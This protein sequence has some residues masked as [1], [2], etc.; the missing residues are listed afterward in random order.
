MISV[1][2]VESLLPGFRCLD[3]ERLADYQTSD[4]VNDDPCYQNKVSGQPVAN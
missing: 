3:F 1:F 4:I 2:I